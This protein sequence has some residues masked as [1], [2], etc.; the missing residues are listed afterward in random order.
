MVGV[1]EVT[2]TS[3]DT[4]ALFSTEIT[5]RAAGEKNKLYAEGVFAPRTLIIIGLVLKIDAASSNNTF[6]GHKP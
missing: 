2:L 1:R 6:V 5:L 3:L 4:D